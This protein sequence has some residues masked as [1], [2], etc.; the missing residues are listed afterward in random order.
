MHNDI[1][2]V[3]E[4]L[5]DLI[6]D[7]KSQREQLTLKFLKQQIESN[8]IEDLIL[9]ISKY[10][11]LK[12]L[13]INIEKH[14]FGP[15]KVTKILQEISSCFPNLNY[16]NLNLDDNLLKDIGSSKLGQAFGQHFS[17]LTSLTLFFKKNSI[18]E[19]GA[20][21]IGIGIGQCL[22]LEYLSLDFEL[23][24]IGDSGVKGLALGLSE[25][26]KLSQL[27]L[28]LDGNKIGD[29]GAIALGEGISCLK[30]LK[31]LNIF[32]MQ[33]IAFFYQFQII[34]YKKNNL[35][36]FSQN[37]NINLIF[38]KQYLLMLR[39]NK[40]K[41]K[42]LSGLSQGIQNCSNLNSLYLH[43]MMNEIQ[44]EGLANFSKNII[45]CQR[46]SFLFISLYM[47]K[48]EVYNLNVLRKVKKL[49]RLVR[50]FILF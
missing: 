20:S 14:R 41:C 10:K 48:I 44:Y 7:D 32:M 4:S 8:Q 3:F 30:N 28:C 19:I 29:Y 11:K 37:L 23:N 27:I 39:Q 22:N 38:V 35:I 12:S 50:N 46:L 40:I 6:N 33:Q 15:D 5:K 13:T 34:Q 45:K 24:I 26:V 42:G 17:N 2:E 25:C 16:L 18:Q 43:L 49:K 36:L 47:N 21:G 31:F 1:P 9:A